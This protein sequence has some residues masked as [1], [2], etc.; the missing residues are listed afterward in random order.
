MTNQINVFYTHNARKNLKNIDSEN[1]RKIV[2]KNAKIFS[3]DFLAVS[4]PLS[5]IFEG[6]YRIRTGDYRTV[7]EFNKESKTIFVLMIKHRKDIYKD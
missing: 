6:L 5:G 2:I 7:F 1:A 3:E 4:K